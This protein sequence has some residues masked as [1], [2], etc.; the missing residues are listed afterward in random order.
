MKLPSEE[1]SAQDLER[2]SGRRKSELGMRLDLREVSGLT[3][4]RK[5]GSR[6]E[7]PSPLRR[8]QNLD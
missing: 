5:M 1:D 6:F 2:A 4:R 7:S 8:N 3:G